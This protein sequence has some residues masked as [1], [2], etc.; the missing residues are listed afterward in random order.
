MTCNAMDGG[1][2]S[3]PTDTNVPTVAEL[4]R[5]SVLIDSARTSHDAWLELRRLKHEFRERELN[6]LTSE[7]VDTGRGDW[8]VIGSKNFLDQVRAV[9]SLHVPEMLRGK[10]RLMTHQILNRIFMGPGTGYNGIL[11]MHDTGTGKTRT[12]IEIVEQYAHV[13]RNKACVIGPGNVR[14]Q[15]RKEIVSSKDAVFRKGRWEL[16]ARNWG[17]TV[18]ASAAQRIRDPHRSALDAQLSAMVDTRYEFF[19][20]TSF[21][22]E[23]YRRDANKRAQAFS[24]R[25]IVVDEA[26]NLRPRKGRTGAKSITR[27]LKEIARTCFNVKIVLM[28]ATPMFDRAEEIVDL[29]NILRC[30][31]DLAE[32]DVNEIFP[33]DGSVNEASL[34]EGVR[35]Y[36]STYT[37]T[38]PDPR[39]PARLDIRQ[40][41][42]P[43]VS[44]KWPAKARNGSDSMGEAA[45]MC[46]IPCSRL[47]SAHHTFQTSEK[48]GKSST[49]DGAEATN[50]VFPGGLIGQRGF[51][52]V[53]DTRT[54]TYASGHEGAF[55]KDLLAE[56]S[57]K[58][59]R[60]VECVCQS[61]GLV[62]IYTNFVW[63]GVKLLAASLEERG[64]RPCEFEQAI[65]KAARGRTSG[66]CYATLSDGAPVDQILELARSSQNKD[67]GVIKVLL[68]TKVVAEGMDMAFIREVHIFE[69]WWNVSREEQVIGRAVRYGSHD[70][71]APDERNV[72]VFRYGLTLP[73]NLEGFD[74]E[75]ARTA[76][77]KQTNISNVL[78]ILH[79]ESFDCVMNKAEAENRLDSFPPKGQTCNHTTSRGIA[80][81]VKTEGRNELQKRIKGMCDGASLEVHR[82][83]NRGG[84]DVDEGPFQL[85]VSAV[86]NSLG[87]ALAA[88]TVYTLSELVTFTGLPDDVGIRA[89]TEIL[90]RGLTLT[91]ATPP[92]KSL[93]VLSEDEYAL[94]ETL[95]SRHTIVT[96]PLS[97]PKPIDQAED[98]GWEAHVLPLTDKLRVVIAGDVDEQVV[99]DM[100]IDRALCAGSTISSIRK[101]GDRGAASLERAV[102]LR[103][104]F[105]KLSASCALVF[106]AKRGAACSHMSRAAIA[107]ALSSKGVPA[108]PPSASRASSC[109]YAEYSLRK[110]GLV[111]R[112]EATRI[113]ASD[114]HENEGDEDNDGT[115]VDHPV[116]TR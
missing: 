18:Y 65:T 85:V 44:H 22:N 36:L 17:G 11:L 33:K 103:G 28:T 106:V 2:T 113:S 71:L 42:V 104:H 60:I 67:G 107:Q 76:M 99:T 14:P 93:I 89:I 102:D 48:S 15:F 108:P 83:G 24:D 80:I 114:D 52:S 73:G 111:A 47:Q 40:A 57:P 30:N 37:R 84:W 66:P 82:I 70:M 79:S 4:T 110:L 72:T 23:W 56:V 105:A 16:G 77:E 112:T 32:L 78:E 39:V 5:I 55:S 100:A 10:T 9:K 58:A 94:A 81:R 96:V 75:M 25:V 54:G 92:G 101:S 34:R 115:S 46:H 27:A 95:G 20:W 49:S 116:R 64:F 62:M 43:G 61:T 50:A 6:S 109:L 31:D 68:C 41:H 90:H 7:K 53:F 74:H 13:M 87:D 35:G 21:A 8:P 45:I 91:P 51:L 3:H 19:G 38:L 86:R 59:A 69:G 29:V 12:A 88:G 97:M 1:S 26:H 98:S 63:A